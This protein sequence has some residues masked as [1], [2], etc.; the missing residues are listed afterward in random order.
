MNKSNRKVPL[1][2]WIWRS[3][4]KTA[5]IPL[6]LVELVFINIYFISNNWSMHEMISLTHKEANENLTQ[7][8]TLESSVI[9]QQLAGITYTTQIYANETATAL[10]SNAQL[11]SEDATRLTYNDEGSYYSTM[12]SGGA[13]I[14]Y[15]GHVPVGT[16]EREKVAQV[17]QT[18]ELMK[19]IQ[20][21]HPLVS[22]IYLNT[23]DSLNIIYPYFDVITQYTS[24]M[25]I[26]T[27]NFYYEADATHNPQRKPKWTNIYLDPAGHGWMASCIDPVYVNDFLEGVVGIDVTVNTITKHVLDMNLPWDGY[28][29]LVGEDGSILALPEKGEADWGLSELTDHSYNEAILEDTFKPDQFNLYKRENLTAFTDQLRR[30]NSGLSS[31]TLNHESKIISWNTIDETGWKLILIIPEKNIYESINQTADHLNSIGT[32]MIAGLLLFYLSFFGLLFKRARRLSLNISQPLLSINSMVRNI[33]KGFYYHHSPE[34]A[35]EEL[36]ETSQNLVKMGK[37]LG[38]AHRELLRTQE[39]LKENE[40]YQQVLIDSLDDVIIEVDK[41]GNILDVRTRD[42]NNLAI[43]Y[44]SGDAHNLTC[45]FNQNDADRYLSLINT[46]IETGITESIEYQIETPKGLRWFQAR[47]SLIRSGKQKAVVSARDITE[48]IV[49]EQSI[50]F[51][52]EAAEKASLA[53]SQFLSNMS[54]ELRTPL[55]AV[56]GFAQLLNMDATEPLSESQ[57]EFVRE[58]EKAGRHLLD[59]INEVLDLAKVE[60]GKATISIEPVSVSDIMEDTLAMIKPLADANDI[61]IESP[62][63]ENRL[64]YVKADF[65]RIKQVF[66][67]LLSN[68]VK[69]NKE[70]GQI[71]FFCERVDSK[72]RFHIIDTGYGIPS[73]ELT[74]IFDPFYR[75]SNT[76]QHV[77]GTGIGLTMVKQLT[78]MMGGTVFVESVVG[79]GSHFYVEFLITKGIHDQPGLMQEISGEQNVPQKSSYKILYV[80]DNPANQLLIQQ[81]FKPFSFIDL[82]TASTAQE[83]LSISEHTKLDIVLLDIDL[84][85]MNG[86]DLFQSLRKIPDLTDTFIIAISANA[87]EKDIEKALSMG[88]YD[89]ITKPIDVTVFTEKIMNLLFKQK[90]E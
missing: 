26:P 87:M 86:Y 65:I 59:L 63:C 19:A 34:F 74:K 49:M 60:S 24:H 32:W 77:E 3:Y 75:L 88:F 42:E 82:S 9:Q 78:D 44:I 7:I 62:V 80:E 89:Y 37:E 84:P 29:I 47:I 61:I 70:H 8:A 51:A 1:I 28:G 21:T 27:Y 68:A 54:H 31:I 10:Q 30:D 12:D 41:N 4:L 22:S 13:A 45:I 14:F 33:G 50:L 17:L 39:A 16:K 52:K 58:I 43:R 57:K 81:L 69:Y 55:N 90:N 25:D 56:L 15:S 85:D 36:N 64:L 40:A 5:L 71:D 11:N 76:E 48:R 83:G 72:L 23:Y 6:I 66:I 53:K 2:Q 38:D 35:V 73:H 18:Q 20:Q 67:N 46:V 79:Q